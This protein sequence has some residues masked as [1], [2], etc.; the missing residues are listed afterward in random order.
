M[1]NKEDE[2]RR[3]LE[4]LEIMAE[5]VLIYAFLH[6]LNKNMCSSGLGLGLIV[7]SK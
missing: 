6:T 7:V 2:A 4:E 5:K 1:K 3:R